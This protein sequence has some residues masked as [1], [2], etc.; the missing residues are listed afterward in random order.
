MEILER[1][2]LLADAQELDRLAGDRAHRQRRAAASVAV[3]ARQHDAGEAD[4]LV[5]GL[6]QIDRVLAGQRVGD[7]QDLV[8]P[9][10]VADFRHLRHQR[11]VDMGAAGGVEQDDVVALQPRGGLGAFGD[12]DR[13]VLAGDDR[14]RVDADLLAQ[15]RELLLRRRALDVER[16]H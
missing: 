4:P 10:G 1:V 14:Q 11:L 16:G 13:V 12:A 2:H 9:R 7:E 8:R 5:E 15:H 6:G 3:H